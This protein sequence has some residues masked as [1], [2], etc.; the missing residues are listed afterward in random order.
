MKV[1]L[2]YI[3]IPFFLLIGISNVFSQTNIEKE[4]SVYEMILNDKELNWTNKNTIL[5]FNRTNLDDMAQEILEI[6]RVKKTVLPDYLES[7]FDEESIKR[8]RSDSSYREVL[9]GLL[10]KS[11]NKIEIKYI[12]NSFFKLESIKKERFN[13]F[14][15]RKI[16]KGWNRISERYQSNWA[17]E[18][19][20]VSFHGNYMTVYFKYYCGGLCGSG[21]LLV[22][23]KEC[24]KW[25]LITRINIWV[26]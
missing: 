5:V 14:F 6:L 13:S 10:D 19:S 15:L 3:F 7:L 16:D 18:F 2:L 1:N 24:Q 9:H 4:Y 17:V 21:N 8:Y 12:S 22:F 20:R 26:S 25:K 11:N 23:E